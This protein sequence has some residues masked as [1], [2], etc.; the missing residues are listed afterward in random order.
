MAAPEVFDNLK[1]R[2]KKEDRLRPLHLFFE[3]LITERKSVQ[4]HRLKE[5][6]AERTVPGRLCFK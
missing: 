3:Y 4:H 6:A 1:E 2:E 5:V